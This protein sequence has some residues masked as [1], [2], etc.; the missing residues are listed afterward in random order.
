MKP[1][2]L[3]CPNNKWYNIAFGNNFTHL[4]NDL[5]VR[6]FDV[7]IQMEPSNPLDVIR[8]TIDGIVIKV[9]AEL[10]HK[11]SQTVQCFLG[12]QIIKH[13][14]LPTV[15]FCGVFKFLVLV[16]INTVNATVW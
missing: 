10:Q 8:F 4:L 2:P 14:Y 12:K 16:D 7:W 15:S 11:T 9:G 5:P 3:T 1:I 6:A 13:K